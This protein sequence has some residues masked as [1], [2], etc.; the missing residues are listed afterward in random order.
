MPDNLVIDSI[1]ENVN[2]NTATDPDGVEIKVVNP[3]ITLSKTGSETFDA[4]SDNNIA[5]GGYESGD[6]VTYDFVIKNESSEIAKD[7]ELIDNFEDTDF[8]DAVIQSVSY[9]SS[10]NGIDYNILGEEKYVDKS[11]LNNSGKDEN[12]MLDTTFLQISANEY[13]KTTV[14]LKLNPSNE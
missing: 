10:Q 13:I 2:A 6:E 1:N 11:V 5:D 4:N 9:S 7:V 3:V 12:I 14:T 8:S